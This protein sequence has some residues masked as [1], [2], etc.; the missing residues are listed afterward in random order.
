MA[1]NDE[2]LNGISNPYVE[3]F[4]LVIDEKLYIFFDP[5]V[6]AVQLSGPRALA[7]FRYDPG[8]KYKLPP[9]FVIRALPVDVDV[10]CK[11]LYS[12]L[13]IMTSWV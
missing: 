9:S 6:F 3:P 13:Y 10:D 11:F 2:P 5:V 1:A 7:T 4:P 12:L 8:Y